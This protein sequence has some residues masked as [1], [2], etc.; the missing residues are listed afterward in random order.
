MVCPGTA[1]YVAAGAHRR[2]G[3]AAKA[4]C[5]A[6]MAKYSDQPNFIPFIVE[7]GGRINDEARAWVEQLCDAQEAPEDRGHQ[8]AVF[9]DVSRALVKQQGYMPAQI[10]EEIRAPDRAVEQGFGDGAVVSGSSSGGA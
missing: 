5:T 2:P 3:A 7:T 1:R 10:V 9:R 4:Y 6:K 8:S